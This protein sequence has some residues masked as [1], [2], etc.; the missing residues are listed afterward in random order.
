MDDT[1]STYIVSVTQIFHSKKGRK[2]VFNTGL[3]EFSSQENDLVGY[4]SMNV[5][6]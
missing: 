4:P 3:W 6:H 5:L 2:F 1:V